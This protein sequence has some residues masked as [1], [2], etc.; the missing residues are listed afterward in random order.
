MKKTLSLLAVIALTSAC[1]SNDVANSSE[2]PALSVSF[3]DSAW[4]GIKLPA[5][6]QCKK[7]G[8][9]GST[10]AMTVSNVPTG[11]VELQV[12]YSDISWEGGKGGFHGV[13]G[14]T[15]TGGNKASLISVPGD[16]VTGYPQGTRLVKANRGFGAWKI[17]KGYMPPCST[18]KQT[19]TYE[20][21]VFAID[22]NGK[23]LA[24]GKI[25]LAKY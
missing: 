12:E 24:E 17:H 14:H 1:A 9:K 18:K 10:P 21:K 7:N 4:N 3:A 22:V 8:G 16:I 11:T 20:A 2:A 5:G 13:V 15:H 6:Q 23:Q 19:H 25:Q